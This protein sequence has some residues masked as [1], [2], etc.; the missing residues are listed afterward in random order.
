MDAFY[1]LQEWDIDSY[2]KLFEINNLFDYIVRIN[3][4]YLIMKIT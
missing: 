4:K 3:V 1:T 2:N